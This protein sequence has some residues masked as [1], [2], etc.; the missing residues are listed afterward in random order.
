M[1]VRRT[2]RPYRLKTKA[3]PR[4]EVEKLLKV[5]QDAFEMI[6]KLSKKL[7]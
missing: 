5:E 6:D 7:G 4:A 2:A 3:T 1:L